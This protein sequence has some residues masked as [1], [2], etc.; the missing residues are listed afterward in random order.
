MGNQPA[1]RIIGVFFKPR[2]ARAQPEAIAPVIHVAEHAFTPQAIDLVGKQYLQV[3]N[4]VFL[5]FIAAGIGIE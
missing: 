4:G 5:G 1:Q 3:T 2:P